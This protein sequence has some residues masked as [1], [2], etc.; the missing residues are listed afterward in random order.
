MRSLG[1]L[2]WCVALMGERIAFQP[3]SLR[4]ARTGGAG[5]FVAKPYRVEDVERR[6]RQIAA[7]R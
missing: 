1:A 5:P 2:P 6:L 4:L 7:S 3:A